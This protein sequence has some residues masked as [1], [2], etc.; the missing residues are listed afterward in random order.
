MMNITAKKVLKSAMSREGGL[1]YF[2]SASKVPS[3]ANSDG[4]T[5]IPNRLS[6]RYAP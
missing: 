4:W 5:R 2:A 3:L 1:R 6:H